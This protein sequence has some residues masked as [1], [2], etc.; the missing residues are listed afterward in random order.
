MKNWISL[1]FLLFLI[2]GCAHKEEGKESLKVS[3]IVSEKQSPRDLEVVKERILKKVLGN[4][5][6]ITKAFKKYQKPLYEYL[7]TQ[8]ANGAWP[9]I[10]Y[11]DMSTVTWEPVAHLYRILELCQAWASK[12]SKYYQK[13]E[14]REAISKG[15]DYWLKLGLERR[16]WWYT[17][18]EPTV[19]GKIMLIFQAE[20]TK[21]QYKKGLKILKRAKQDNTGANFIWQSKIVIYRAILENNSKLLKEASVSI[22]GAINDDNPEGIQKDGAFFQ[23]GPCL[24]NNGYGA[25]FVLGIARLA[26][27][28]RNTSFAIPK[29]KIEFLDRYILDKSQWMN[30]GNTP[31]F[32]T[33]G[34]QITRPSEGKTSYLAPL[35]ELMLQLSSDREADYRNMLRCIKDMQAP[36]L[37]GNRYFFRGHIMTQHGVGWYISARMYSNRIMNTDILT[38]KE[39]LYS[40]Y[41]AEGATCIM[42]TGKEYLDIFPVWNWQKIPGTTVEMRPQTPGNP[43]RKGESSFA[44]GVSTGQSGIA[45]FDLKRDGLNAKKAWFF[46]PE[47]V[48]CLGAGINC[49]SPYNV[50][51]T[52]NQCL[53]S[54]KVITNASF[55]NALTGKEYRLKNIQWIYHAGITY[56]FPFPQDLFLTQKTQLGS[57]KK[58]SGERE[59]AQVGKDV[60]SLWLEHGSSP[61]DGGYEY[62]IIPNVK[63]ENVEAFI[64]EQIVKILSNTPEKQA[65][66]YTKDKNLIIGMAF[67]KAGNIKFKDIYL[68]TDKPCVAI[69]KKLKEKEWLLYA[70]DP[71]CKNAEIKF[72][73]Q[74]SGIAKREIIAKLPSDAYA[75]GAV[76]MEIKSR[77]EEK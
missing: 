26:V 43:S 13:P 3:M 46:F 20:L 41:L 22:S 33:I 74:S 6:P 37:I 61:K 36:S 7:K 12:E 17:I 15:F 5:I 62:F 45:A 28:F 49:Q 67:Y 59:D 63:P 55:P 8:N 64:S 34:R 72:V 44:G 25:S 11:K 56:A 52:V 54:G 2:C 31:D 60:F 77:Q 51:T 21:E 35:S 16:W 32:G 27:L 18:G 38:C 19:V 58:I 66:A 24:Y 50:T 73:F 14:L 65:V 10:D 23:H 76:A 40:H 48:V 30:H 42:R 29:D 4:P 57:W 69:V 75:G 68:E 70:A 47:L 39:G 53:L 9:D 71:S 1:L